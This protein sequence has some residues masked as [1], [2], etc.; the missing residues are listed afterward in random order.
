LLKNVEASLPQYFY[1]LPNFLTNQNA[2][3]APAPLGLQMALC[4]QAPKDKIP[5]L[6]TPQLQRWVESG[7]NFC[8]D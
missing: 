4:T 6:M 1:I 5:A 3:P 2:P 7:C 8:S